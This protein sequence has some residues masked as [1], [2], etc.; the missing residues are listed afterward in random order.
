[1]GR[2][3]VG[4]GRG[5]FDLHAI[6]AVNPAGGTSETVLRPGENVVRVPQGQTNWAEACAAASRLLPELMNGSPLRVQFLT[7]TR[8]VEAD[9]LVKTPDFG[10]FFQRLLKR[11]DELGEQL[12]GQPPRPREQVERL[13]AL[14]D[15]VR[16]VEAEVGWVELWGPSNRSGRP[17]P[18]SG[19][20]G[21]AAYRARDWDDLLPWLLFGQGIQAGKLAVKGNGVY[22]VVLPGQP[23]YWEWAY[24]AG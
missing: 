10:V 17:T 9:A 5:R 6:W 21:R 24:Q 11:I 4:P 23:A 14:A 20:V 8:L 7:P 13:H 22:Q 12:A 1:M 2:C 15:R 18:M 19:F 3:G 16:L